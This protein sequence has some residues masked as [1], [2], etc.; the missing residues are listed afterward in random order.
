[1]V[2][3][4]N[5]NGKA[6]RIPS[7]N[8]PLVE[9]PSDELFSKRNHSVTPPRRD[10]SGPSKVVPLSSFVA[11]ARD[12]PLSC[13]PVCN[14]PLMHASSAIVREIDATAS[15]VHPRSK[16]SLP[17]L[18]KYLANEPEARY[19]F[20]ARVQEGSISALARAEI[21]L[22]VKELIAFHEC[23]DEVFAC[24]VD[25]LDRLL[26]ITKMKA[27]H[28]RVAAVA[29]FLITS[30]CLVEEA[31]QP[32]VDDL[33]ANCSPE[34]SSNDLKRMELVV[35]NK[36]QWKLPSS[37]SMSMVHDLISFAASELLLNDARLADLIDAVTP[38]F[39]ACAV[40]YELLRFKP[41][42]IATAII[43]TEV[44]G[45]TRLSEEYLRSMFDREL[46]V[47]VSALHDCDRM[48]ARHLRIT[49]AL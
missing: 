20:L 38:K 18:K 37:S 22:W 5:G 47:N 42:V 48:V 35:L 26:A 21:L 3:T 13:T 14:T 8:R 44:S 28:L 40:S 10:S 24:T 45:I 31:E 41:S 49:A 43:I 16:F 25:L 29:C 4:G 30:K 33:V 23:D 12:S 46:G 27:K 6:A 19:G 15:V 34:F 17:L 9:T 2:V 1:M 11:S 39:V 7:A 36:L 32:L